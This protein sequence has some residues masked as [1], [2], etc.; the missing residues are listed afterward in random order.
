MNSI[1]VQSRTLPVT[2]DFVS[3]EYLK[4]S[5]RASTGSTNEKTFS[6]YFGNL[7]PFFYYL[8]LAGV[9][10][11]DVTEE[12]VYRYK[13]YL[14]GKE[15]A[16]RDGS[17]IPVKEERCKPTTIQNYIMA[18]RWFYK[19]Y[20]KQTGRPNFMKDV[21][22]AKLDR[23]NKKDYLQ[24][25]Q[26]KDV[27]ATIDTS[28]VQGKRDYAMLLL[29]VTC[30]LR[31]I[32]AVRANT[33]DIRPAG[34][35]TAIYVQGK[36]KQERTDLVVMPERTEAAIREYL[37]ARAAD[38]D[39][40]EALFTSTSNNNRG[41]RVTTRT[42]RGIVKHYLRAAGQ[43]SSRLTAH[44]LRHTAC[45]TALKSGLDVVQVQQFARHAD[46]TST[47]IYVK[48][49]AKEENTTSFNIDSF[50]FDDGK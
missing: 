40:S 26:V 33:E 45:F 50:L 18:L 17:F 12:D 24:P 49:L 23:D 29:L 32:E 39:N 11:Q 7:K 20:S 31:T 14:E 34:S 46:I 37:K 8:Q 41:Q 42:V 36:G 28:T 16:R 30:G 47:Q 44:S 5:L 2:Q 15:V 27:L 10:L 4:D 9:R 1:T 38:G 13:L 25:K 19:V 43:D 6:T 21:K 3:I 35:H 22:G 48:H